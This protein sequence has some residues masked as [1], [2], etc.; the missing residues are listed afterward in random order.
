MSRRRRVAVVGA[1]LAGLLA[2]SELRRRGHSVTVYEGSRQIAGLARSFVDAE[3]FTYD[4]GAHFITNRL[5]AALGISS[6]C[7]DV[8]D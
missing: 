6:Q 5:A 7:R 4:F 1:G 2:A 3:G 8:G